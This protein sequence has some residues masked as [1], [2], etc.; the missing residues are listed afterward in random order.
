VIAI[1]IFAGFITGKRARLPQGRELMSQLAQDTLFTAD[2]KLSADFDSKAAVAAAEAN[3]PYGQCNATA[4]A[5]ANP[6]KRE[7]ALEDCQKERMD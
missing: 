2:G 3:T 4:A 7:K 1:G 5:V 6:K